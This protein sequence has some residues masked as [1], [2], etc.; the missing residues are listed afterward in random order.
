MRSKPFF[1]DFSPNYWDLIFSR[2][3]LLIAIHGISLLQSAMMILT[4]MYFFRQLFTRSLEI[5]EYE[6]FCYLIKQHPEF[7]WRALPQL[8]GIENCQRLKVNNFR[9]K[10][11]RDFGANQLPEHRKTPSDGA[12]CSICFQTTTRCLLRRQK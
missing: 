11:K 6:R 10:Q 2:A 9:W 12:C 8:E 4:W 5:E 7:T 1:P 3:V